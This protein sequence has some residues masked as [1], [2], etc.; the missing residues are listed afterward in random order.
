MIEYIQADL[1]FALLV[2]VCC[3]LYMTLHMKSFFLGITSI[4]NI[5]M[6]I[7]LSLCIYTYIF[8]IRY[9][10]AVHIA[11]VIIIIGIGSDDVFV[12]H[13][14]WK[15]AFTIPAIKN[16][17]ILRLSYTFRKSASTMIVTSATSAVA[18]FAC[19]FSPIMP[20]RAF[21]M[22]ATIVVIVCFLVTVIVEPLTY[23]VFEK[24]LIKDPE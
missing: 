1:A 21:G 20:I 8:Q 7:P 11:V 6:S 16:R 2:A 15:G 3:L 14:T 19:Y 23:F 17:P 18:F 12:F 22:F 5:F 4:L 13:D 24:Y 9:F 10:S